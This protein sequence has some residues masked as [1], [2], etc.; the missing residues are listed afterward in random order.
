MNRALLAFCA[1]LPLIGVGPSFAQDSPPAA[2]LETAT[3][4]PS[5]PIDPLPASSAA[6]IQQAAET[7]SETSLT[8][9]PAPSRVRPAET[10]DEGGLWGLLD[11]AELEARASGRLIRDEALNA[12]VRDVMCRVA[13]REC[14]DIRVYVMNQPYMNAFMAANGYSEVWSGLLL[15]AQDESE[16]AYVL[17]HEVGHFSENHSIE[18]MRAIRFRMN[19]ML[20]VS[21][22]VAVAGANAAANSPTNAQQILDATGQVIDAI[23]L[24]TVASL[25]GFQR[26]HEEEADEAGFARLVAAGYDP[27]AAPRIWR[28]K[29]AETAASDNP[30]VRRREARPS[31]F[32]THPLTVNRAN[33]LDRLAQE[34]SGMSGS[35]PNRHRAA[36]RP[37][38]SDWLRDD[39]R[40]RD[41]G[42]T[43]HLLDR[44][45]AANQDL[46]VIE[47]Y[48][49]E[50]F[51][52][53]R[54][55]GDRERAAQHYRA[56]ASHLDAPALVWR[57]LGAIEEREGNREAA[58][59]HY[60]RYLELEPTAAD[61]LLFEARIAGK[62]GAAQ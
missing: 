26:E 15:R 61:R 17:G 47:F 1:I 42:S 59:A 21:V 3:T 7:R 13:D 50:V 4:Q 2:I 34:R 46:G 32:D 27:S 62:E 25:F 31:I 28:Y 38:L 35:N 29:I 33:R 30:D 36:I 23:H 19:A 48:R 14:G 20:V 11:R 22:G 37:F 49:A 56:A 60:R 18:H 40:R 45:A 16:L 41:F 44:L 43:L 9:I 5:S 10:T 54:A 55:D 52:L 12:Y 39:L 6:P 24:A 53:R 51:R 57:E 8:P 58:L